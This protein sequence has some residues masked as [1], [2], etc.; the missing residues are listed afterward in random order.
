MITNRNAELEQIKYE[1]KSAFDSHQG[2]DYQ[3]Q[4]IRADK[5]LQRFERKQLFMAEALR[6]REAAA[7]VRQEMSRLH[8]LDVE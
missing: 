3:R 4:T 2:P 6:E 8:Q 1:R 7:I 5:V